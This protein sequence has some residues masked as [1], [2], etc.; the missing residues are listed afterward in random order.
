[1]DGYGL[2][3]SSEG[4]DAAPVTFA[5]RPEALTFLKDSQVEGYRFSGAELVD[6]EQRLVKNRYFVIGGDGQLT[7][8][9]EDNGPRDTVW[10]I[11]DVKPGHDRS[12]GFEAIVENILQGWVCEKDLDATSRFSFGTPRSSEGPSPFCRYRPSTRRSPVHAV[13][14]GSPTAT[15]ATIKADMLSRTRCCETAPRMVPGALAQIQSSM[16][17]DDTRFRIVWNKALELPTASNIP[18]IP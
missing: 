13:S 5:G 8:A 12:V 14:T 18:S 9:G 4:A 15:A 1:M 7:P 6:P 17:K 16:V 10:E 2:D 11:E 3:G